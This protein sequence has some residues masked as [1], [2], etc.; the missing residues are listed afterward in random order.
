[1]EI[2]LGVKNFG[3]IESAEVNINGF[4]V[5]V[6]NNNSGKTYLMQLIYGI[7]HNFE[8][9]VYEK[10][11]DFI[12]VLEG[13]KRDNKIIVDFEIIKT[14]E[15]FVNG[16]LEEKKDSL[17]YD[18]FNE[19]IAIGQ[20]YLKVECDADEKREFCLFDNGNFEAL[21]EDNA[22]NS[23]LF[24]TI[25]NKLKR[26]KFIQMVVEK[27]L[28]NQEKEEKSI[29]IHLGEEKNRLLT[30]T[31]EKILQSIIGSQ[32]E[33]IFLPA[34]RTGLLSLY[35]EFF[36][37]KADEAVR[38]ITIS[39]GREQ[40]EVKI[41]A[42]RLGL[43]QPVYDFIR[44][45]QTFMPANDMQEEEVE[46]IHFINQNLIDGK[47]LINKDTTT[48]YQGGEN[49]TPIPLYLS[50]SMIN[51]LTPIIYVLQS[52]EEFK[53]IIWDEIDTSLHPQKQMELVRLLVRMNNAGYR[54]VVSTHSDTM[55]SK[56]NN[57][58]IL[59]YSNSL[60][61]K[62]TE[63]LEKAGLEENDL[64]NSQ[65]HVYQFENQE[66]GKSIVNELRYD[67]FTGYEFS[68]FNDSVE[69]LLKETKLVME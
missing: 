25:I 62:R 43:T 19:K 68:Q 45:M 28:N 24:E 18:I 1:M 42:V 67:N 15:K 16:I 22:E 20:I 11:E 2:I 40:K 21:E 56:I 7:R 53:Y 41:N 32:N 69:K 63:I 30:V 33:T 36:A 50:S 8:Q 31:F 66:N 14:F 34:A 44:F 59:S 10:K 27:S 47:L 61:E 5:F 55:A 49:S 26:E 65:I 9:Y 64:L 51:E 29:N 4:S 52:V 6:G 35:K 46:L 23:R 54:L 57:L 58:C 12:A 39:K 38:A 3:K 60:K 13:I 17:V 37:N 48:L